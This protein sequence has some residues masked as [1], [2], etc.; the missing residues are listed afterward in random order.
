[1]ICIVTTKN[2]TFNVN[3]DTFLR[4]SNAEYLNCRTNNEAEDRR[5]EK[6]IGDTNNRPTS[7]VYGFQYFDSTLG[8]PIFWVNK[9]VDA[10]GTPV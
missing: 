6:I 2:N 3:S 10:T 9:W 7:P 5:S 8:K 4:I 1:M